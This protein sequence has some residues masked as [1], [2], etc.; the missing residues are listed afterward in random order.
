[1]RGKRRRARV[2]PR[3]RPVMTRPDPTDEPIDRI[4]PPSHDEGVSGDGTAC[5]DPAP[6][7]PLI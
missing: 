4:R 1:M 6:V 2:I 7:R 5:D 3:A